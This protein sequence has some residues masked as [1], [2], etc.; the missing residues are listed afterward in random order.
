MQRSWICFLFVASLI[1]T[2]V[3]AADSK[4]DLIKQDRKRIEGTWR[5]AALEVNGNKTA[6]QDARKLSVVNGPDGTWTLYSEGQVVS[7]GTNLFDPTQKPKTIDLTITAADGN[8]NV[9][10]GI[11]ELGEQRRKLCFVPPG[12]KRPTEF[13]SPTGSERILVSF[14]REKK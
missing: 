2:T 1:W 5:V 4:E 13:T 12:Q 14:E 7:K 11:Y 8:G 9:H 10:L 6:D 3:F